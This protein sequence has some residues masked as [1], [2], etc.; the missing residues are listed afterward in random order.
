MPPTFDELRLKH[1]T[2]SLIGKEAIVVGGTSGIGMGIAL[3]L[4]EAGAA[5]TIVG[6]DRTRA[7]QIVEQ[8]KSAAPDG[9][10]AVHSFKQC[11][12]FLLSNVAS[13]A[14]ELTAESGSKKLDFLVLTQGMATTQGHTPTAEGLDEKLALHYYSRVAFAKALAPLLESATPG[15]RV[16]SV[17]SAGVH[18]T[19]GGWRDDTAISAANYSLK[20][21]ADGAGFYND[22]AVD[23][24]SREHPTLSFTH[25]APGF[26]N[27][28]W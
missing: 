26:V 3:R 13:C 15:G 8:M 23:S 7:V 10:A 9:S 18:G 16:L 19:Y 25:A 27:T 6:R 17:L 5:V 11:N 14:A 24:L 2:V 12:C 28:N 22:L 21:A 1:Q 4:A 20:N